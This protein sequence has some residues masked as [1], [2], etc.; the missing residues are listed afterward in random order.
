MQVATSILYNTIPA[1]LKYNRLH[2]NGSTVN[3]LEEHRKDVQAF[4]LTVSPLGQFTIYNSTCIL[5][6]SK[7]HVDKKT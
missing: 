1:A 3:Y 7:T 2:N 4:L 6:Y 5:F